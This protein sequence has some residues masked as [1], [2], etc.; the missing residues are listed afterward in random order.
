MIQF[1]MPHDKATRWQI[2]RSFYFQHSVYTSYTRSNIITCNKYDIIAQ[3]RDFIMRYVCVCM[4]KRMYRNVIYSFLSFTT[5]IKVCCTFYF[6]IWTAGVGQSSLGPRPSVMIW[7]CEKTFFCPNL[8]DCK[9]FQWKLKSFF[10]NTH[11]CPV[12]IDRAPL[13]IKNILCKLLK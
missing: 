11:A 9:T 12:C 10:L 2:K 4:G 8:T 13:K 5:I 1:I 6:G 7:Y 3:D